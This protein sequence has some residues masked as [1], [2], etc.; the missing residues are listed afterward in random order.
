[1]PNDERTDGWSGAYGPFRPDWGWPTI[2]GVA[3]NTL[4]NDART[5][6]PAGR[7]LLVEKP[8]WTNARR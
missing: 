1:M 3:F 6:A 8:V 4:G 7:A 5:L 2:I